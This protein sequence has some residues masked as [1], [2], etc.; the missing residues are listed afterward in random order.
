[1][2]SQFRDGNVLAGYGQ[3]AVLQRSLELLPEGV[4]EVLLRTD[5]A[6]YEWDLLKYCAEGKNER[7]GVIRFCVG[8][9]VTPE[10]KA[11]VARVPSSDCQ[12]L[13]RRVDGMEIDTGQQYAEVCYVPNKAAT[14]KHGPH[15]RFLAIREPLPQLEFPGVENQGELP[16]PTMNFQGSGRQKLFAAVTNLDWPGDELIWWHRQRCGKSEEAHSVMKADLGG[17]KLPS[18]TFG[19]NAAWW[20]CNAFFIS[21]RVI[22]PCGISESP[23]R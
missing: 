5:T 1:M 21:S 12:P 16:F 11:A 22:T 13:M 7:F 4:E 8:A 10:F 3:L 14:K 20:A 15:Y 19:A 9:D 6:G 23:I 18:G 17:G 2:Y